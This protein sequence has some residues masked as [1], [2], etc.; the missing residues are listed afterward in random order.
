MKCR[1]EHTQYSASSL[2]LSRSESLRMVDNKFYLNW[3]WLCCFVDK[4]FEH[5]PSYHT[6]LSRWPCYSQYKCMWH[7][8]SK[9]NKTTCSTWLPGKHNRWT[10]NALHLVLLATWFMKKFGLE[11]ISTCFLMSYIGEAVWKGTC[12]VEL[13]TWHLLPANSRWVR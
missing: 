6:Y 13:V 10:N 7:K 9:I 8:T 4:Y 12:F 1:C 3:Q 2:P 11:E 5:L